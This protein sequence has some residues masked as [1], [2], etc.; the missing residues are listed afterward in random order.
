VHRDQR[1]GRRPIADRIVRLAAEG[2][3]GQPLLLVGPAGSGKEITALGIARRLNCVDPENCTPDHVCESCQK[4][5]S[6][7]HPDIRWLGPAPASLEDANQARRVREIL[8]RKIAEPFAEPDYATSQVLIGNPEQPGPLTVRGL[9]QFARRQAFQGRWKVA[10][11][12]DAHR[13]N[14]AAA[15]AFL[16]TLEE[17]PPATLLMLLTDRPSSLLPTILSRCQKVAFEP[18]D[19][20]QLTAILAELKGDI[21]AAARAEAVRLAGG[22][23]RRAVALLSPEMQELQAW[24]VAVYLELGEGRSL[25][26]HIAAEHLNAGILPRTKE[27]GELDL[28]SG[29]VDDAASRRR[30]A[31]V[32]CENLALLT[33]E[34]LACRE[35][36]ADWQPRLASQADRLRAIAARRRTPGLLDDLARIE[37]AKHEIDGNLNLGLVMAG[38]C[39]DLGAHAR[40]DQSIATR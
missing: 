5:L 26:G 36:G 35:R 10:V 8:E 6:F 14:K 2:R 12:A 34:V 29:R 20:E 30:R 3:L 19:D 13:M 24:S 16:K 39:E 31:L 25:A 4:A 1:L 37:R 9:M 32:V 7:Q 17:P 40:R 22:D 27:E 18:Y 38:L 28:K 23:A 21:D 11:V 33:A 15:N